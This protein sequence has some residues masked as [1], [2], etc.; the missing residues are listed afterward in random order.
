[1]N[2]IEIK[3]LGVL[4]LHP[5]L[6]EVVEA[7]MKFSGLNVITSAYRPGDEGVH[8]QMPVRG[9]DL[10][11]RDIATG[12]IIKEDINSKWIYDPDRPSMD[13]CVAHGEGDNFHLHLQVHRNTTTWIE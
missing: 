10:R 3:D 1:M 13:V 8:G 5:K 2:R 7:V 12:K 11:C 6:I 9:V 4:N